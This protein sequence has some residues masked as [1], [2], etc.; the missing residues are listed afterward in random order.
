M[1]DIMG[2][3]E[4]SQKARNEWRC[5]PRIKSTLDKFAELR[6][7]CV[8]RGS[9]SSLYSAARF[10]VTEV[11]ENDAPIF[12]RLADEHMREKELEVKSPRSY[13]WLLPMWRRGDL[14]DEQSE[15]ERRRYLQGLE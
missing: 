1:T 2:W 11:G 9:K 12:I 8:P 4:H 14:K 6:P 5:E 10:I 7:E 13:G 15:N 3:L